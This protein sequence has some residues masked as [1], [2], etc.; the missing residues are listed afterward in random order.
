MDLFSIQQM[1]KNKLL[2]WAIRQDRVP[3]LHPTVPDND[4][5]SRLSQKLNTI[6][7]KGFNQWL[8]FTVQ[9]AY[10]NEISLLY[11]Y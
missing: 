3:P 6:I 8:D 10:M 9:I 4:L 1:L 2:P 11:N 7:Y 5:L